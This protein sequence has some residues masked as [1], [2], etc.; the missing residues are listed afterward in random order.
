MWNPDITRQTGAR[1][2]AI[3]DRIAEDIEHGQLRPGEQMPTHREL[4][5]R[6]GV[7]VGTI[8]RAYAEAQRRG[9]LVGETGRGTYVREDLF[10]DAFP[11]NI[12]AHDDSLIDLSLNLPPVAA[13][14]QLGQVLSSTLMNLAGRPNLSNLLGYQTPIG[15]ER[16]RAAGAAWI[17]RSGMEAQA[18]RVLI[19]SGALHAMTVVFST[20]AKPG[21]TVFTERLTYP[22]MKNL[23][24]LLHLRLQGLDVDEHGIIPEA[25]ERACRSGSARVLYTIP[26]IH[27]P[28]GTVMP[29]ERRREIAR[30][31]EE[32]DISIV[33]DDVHSFMLERPPLPLSSF[34]P[35]RSYYILT[36]SKS[37][38]GG[39][40]IGYLLAPERMVERLAT[41]LRSTVWMAAPLMAE[42]AS[43]W[44]KDGTA[45]RLIEQKRRE[46]GERQEI[47]RR[48]LHGL[49]FRAHPLSFHLW[50]ELPEP[51]RSDEFIAQARRRNVLVTPPEAFVPAR[52]EAPHAVRVCLGAVRTRQQLEK[53]LKIVRELCRSAPNPALSII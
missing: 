21:D 36:T 5:S 9:L 47:A 41:S 18:R 2:L 42:I 32:H 45:E 6:L 53:G 46:A 51:W 24:H 13:S 50:L 11:P 29:E 35:E 17:S 33:E 20:L 25:F 37:I 7:T 31:A 14:D 10:A 8:T 28:L 23:A 40:R 15:A 22:G 16:H 12:A 3:A 1:Y 49:R 30:I 19:T 27:N 34:A 48:I 4:A 39:M 26:T 43:E 38:A 52:E 44:I